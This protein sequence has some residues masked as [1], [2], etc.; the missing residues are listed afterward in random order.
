MIDLATPCASLTRST[1]G[2]AASAPHH[3]GRV[4]PLVHTV[5]GWLQA[6]HGTVAAA[7]VRSMHER[8]G[9]SQ[10]MALDWRSLS[11]QSS[12]YLPPQMFYD[13]MYDTQVG[14]HIRP[15]RQEMRFAREVLDE[16]VRNQWCNKTL[17]E[18]TLVCQQQAGAEEQNQPGQRYP[19]HRIFVQKKGES[20]RTATAII[21]SDRWY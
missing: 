16:R 6:S 10:I 14:L 21:H 12:S 19:P 18:L 5:H 13:H 20:L 15:S 3:M 1:A 4:E 8:S 9:I 11:K 2:S 7:P 17:E